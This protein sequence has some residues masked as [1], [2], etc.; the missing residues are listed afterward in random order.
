MKKLLFII[1]ILL[2]L[3]G[4]NSYIELNNL[5]VINKIGIEHQDSYILYAS[6]ID[7]VDKENINPNEKLIKVEGKTIY[8]L[9]N[10]LSIACDKKI[11]MSHLDL[12]ILNDSIKSH[13]IQELINYFLNNNETREDFLI[14]TADDIETLISKS[15]FQEINNLIE[16]NRND[17]SISIYTT[18]YDLINKYMLNEPI[19]LSNIT[20][21]NEL[22]PSGI[23]KIYNNKITHINNEDAI[24]I[25]YL[26]NNINTYKK[27]LECDYNKYLYLDILSSNTNIIKNK[28]L[29]TNEIKVIDNNCNLNKDTINK[30]FNDNL[31]NNLKKFTN[32]NI[33]IKNTIRSFYE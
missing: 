18:M 19:Y 25:N 15:K 17:T 28:I 16:I 6:I 12:L 7:S 33:T 14:I 32:K 11:Y 8:D 27:S 30:L 4:C 3:T 23:T 21:D 5:A 10:N 22:I 9:I 1:P 29:I 13:E 26:L 20:F 24:Y 2:M 31:L